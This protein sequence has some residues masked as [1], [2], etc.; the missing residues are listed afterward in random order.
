M[1][2][3]KPETVFNIETLFTDINRSF[4]TAAQ[5]LQ[6]TLETEEWLD[7]P[8][9]Y[10]MP[11]MHLSMRLSLSHSDGKV[12]GFFSKRSTQKEES[13]TSLIEVDV[14][15]MPRQPAKVDI[16]WLQRSLN[17]LLG[18]NLEVD[19]K[20]G[21]QSRSALKDFQAAH[22]LPQTGEPGQPTVVRI[23]RMLAAQTGGG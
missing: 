2:N 15:S 23:R 16:E 14:V 7:S 5:Q 10:H 1:A 4:L 17:T 19:G 22:G 13:V 11:K 18:T 20:F 3:Q 9:I 12:K 6:E 21:E 8:Y